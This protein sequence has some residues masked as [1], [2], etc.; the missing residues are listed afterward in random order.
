MNNTI[1]IDKLTRDIKE[2]Y[3]SDVPNAG[4]L[5]EGYLDQCL[6]GLGP[7]ERLELLDKLTYEFKPVISEKPSSP[8]TGPDLVAK[9]FSLFLGKKVSDIDLS[10]AEFLQRLAGSLN[11]VFDS[12][13]ELVGVINLTLLGKQAGLETI[14]HIIGTNL[15]DEVE[16]N[17]LETYLAQIKEAFLLSHQAFKKAAQTKVKEILFELDPQR[18]EQSEPGGLKLGPLRKANL[19]EI[20]QEKFQRV[21]KWFESGRFEKEL[22]RNFERICERSLHDRR[23]L[24]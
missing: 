7:S 24:K 19:F 13:N 1:F 15:H 12:L 16:H 8:K 6:E 21:Q 20:Y 10:S 22:L 9:L 18:I 5:I 4:T 2:L 14:R 23:E 3:S 17:S 11:K